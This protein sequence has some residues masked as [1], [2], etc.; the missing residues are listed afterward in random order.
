VSGLNGASSKLHQHILHHSHRLDQHAMRHLTLRIESP[1]CCTL[2]TTVDWSAACLAGEQD[3]LGLAKYPF[4]PTFN[5]NFSP[6]LTQ[7]LTQ[8]ASWQMLE[9][10]PQLQ[11]L[12]HL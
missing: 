6:L 3:V 8:Q 12:L 10:A 7:L 9:L 1:V 5:A 4:V 2:L 11:Q